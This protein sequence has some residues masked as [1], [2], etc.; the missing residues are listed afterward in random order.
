MWG[1]PINLYD[2]AGTCSGWG[3]I[4]G[5]AKAIANGAKNVGK[6]AV[7]VGK[8]AVGAAKA[9]AS[10]F[11]KGVT[12]VATYVVQKREEYIQI[13]VVALAG[14]D[15]IATCGATAGLCVVAFGVGYSVAGGSATYAVMHVNDPACQR[16]PG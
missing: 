3:C 15:A 13:A 6:A 4:T 7:N 10:S 16:D 12:A 11:V 8:A 5:P 9:V 14:A 1:D 2:L